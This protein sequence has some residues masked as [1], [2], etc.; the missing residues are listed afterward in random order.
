MS[1]LQF[2]NVTYKR[3]G[4]I[5]LGPVDAT[6]PA[7]AS[8]AIMGPNGAGKSLFLELA[9]GLI[10]PSSGQ[11]S[12]AGQSPKSTR[13]TRGYIFQ[14]PINLRRS[15]RDNIR[16][17]QIAHGETDNHD[18]LDAVLSRMGLSDLAELPAAILS[19]GE[20]QRMALARAL[21]T[22]PKV[23]LMDEPT[24]SLDPEARAEFETLLKQEKDKGTQ[25]IWISHNPTQ[26]R[27]LADYVAFIA[28]GTL[29]ELTP[30]DKF[31]KAPKTKAAKDFFATL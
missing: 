7:G 5:L 14:K 8:V 3:D 18:A 1:D 28:S 26:A 11:V 19:G 12:W 20:A 25:L 21:V 29:C 9:H 16:F 24:S 22:N 23:L 31:F 15:V 2:Q 27:A 13:K 4:Q 10:Q 17:A 30:S 6:L